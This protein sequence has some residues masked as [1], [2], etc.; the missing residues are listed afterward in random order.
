[1]MLLGPEINVSRPKIVG[2]RIDQVRIFD[3]ARAPP[4]HTQL[5]DAR[6]L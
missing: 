1:M 5:W 6:G 4:R 2:V 3:G